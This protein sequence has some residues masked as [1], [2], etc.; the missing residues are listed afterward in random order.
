MMA[1]LVLQGIGFVIVFLQCWIKYFASWITDVHSIL[2]LLQLL[3]FIFACI[4][5]CCEPF[6]WQMSEQYSVVLQLHQDELS[7]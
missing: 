4:P 6:C 3:P 2:N 1:Q 7:I 5:L